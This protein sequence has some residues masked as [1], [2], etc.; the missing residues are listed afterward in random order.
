ML[1]SFCGLSDGI[2]AITGLNKTSERPAETEKIIVPTT[3][4]I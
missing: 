2:A 1:I 3:K 4:P